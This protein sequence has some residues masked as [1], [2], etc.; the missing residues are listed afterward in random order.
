MNTFMFESHVMGMIRIYSRR[1]GK[2]DSHVFRIFGN[3]EA[4]NRS[5][6]ETTKPTHG[7]QKEEPPNLEEIQ[8]FVDKVTAP[9]KFTLSDLIWSSYFRINERITNKYRIKRAFLAGDAAHCHSPAGGQGMNL[10]LQD[11]DNLAWKLS[12]VLK[13]QAADP[14]TLLDSYHIE[15]EPHAAST[16][17]MTSRAT[18]A[19]ITEGFLARNIREAAMSTMVM[20]PQVREYSFKNVMQ[21]FVT[22]D[23]GSKL[24]GTSDKGLIKA[25]HFLPD[26]EGLRQRTLEKRTSLIRRLNL[27]EILIGTTQY[28][29]ILVATCPSQTKPRLDLLEKF[30]I[31]ARPYPVK[32]IIVESSWHTHFNQYPLFVLPQEEQDAQTS[33]YS[34]ERMDSPYSITSRVGLLP[35]FPKY[36]DGPSPC[37]LVIVRPD[38]YVAQSKT[39]YNE[40]DLVSAL[41]YFKTHLLSKPN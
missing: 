18:Q 28:T 29:A 35:L 36:F 1:E 22:V 17:K 6:E 25:G 19:G 31:H 24:L 8:A 26:S 21:L 23:G 40:N 41:E 13:G 16:I 14:E 37:V 9:L 38:L 11:A 5:E 2:D 12:L 15:R 32:R 30:W 27:H 39:V 34:E 4:Y 3:V 20:I 10:G 33:F 7:L